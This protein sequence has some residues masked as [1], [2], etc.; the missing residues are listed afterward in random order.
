MIIIGD[1]NCD[2]NSTSPRLTRLE[3]TMNLFNLKQIVPEATRTTPNSSS[4]ID[5]ILTNNLTIHSDCRVI[6][7]A[8]SDHDF[9]YTSV[10][11]K[12]P[13]QSHVEK[14]FRSF[15]NF[16]CDAF[17]NDLNGMPWS[18]LGDATDPDLEAPWMWFIPY[19][20]HDVTCLAFILHYDLINRVMLFCC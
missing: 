1:L 7:C 2:F 18:I 9:I 13:R 17:L 12:I 4:L 20:L 14:T 16:D 15:K 5:V 19:I 8:I 6:P 11:F 10:K 3:E